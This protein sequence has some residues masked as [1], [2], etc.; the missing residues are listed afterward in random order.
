MNEEY[1]CWAEKRL[2]LANTDKDIQGYS[3][4]VFWERNTLNL[5]IMETKRKL[6]E[7]IPAENIE[8]LSSAAESL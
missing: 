7:E 3:N 6:K 4:G 5:Q 8:S 2:E 1:C